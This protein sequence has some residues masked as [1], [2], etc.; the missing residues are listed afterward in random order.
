MMAG[1]LIPWWRFSGVCALALALGGCA[2]LPRWLPG[3]GAGDVTRAPAEAVPAE[4]GSAEHAAAARDGDAAGDDHA[5]DGRLDGLRAPPPAAGQGA[6]ALDLDAAWRLAQLHDPR[7]LAAISARAAS[8]DERAVGRAA[9][10]PQ[11]QASAYRG[12]VR[13]D[14]TMPDFL[15][16]MTTSDLGYDSTS[17]VVQ[18]SQ[19]VLDYGRFAEFRRGAAQ[20]E[21]GVARFAVA[22][23]EAA[24][25][26][27]SAYYRVVLAQGRVDLQDALVDAYTQRVTAL[28]ARYAHDAGTRTEVAETEARLALA[29]ADRVDARDEHALALRA[30]ALL[31]GREPGAL[32]ARAAQLAPAL[33]Q[34]H[35]LLAWLEQAREASPQLRLAER[36][37]TLARV[38]VDAAT[39]GFLPRATL[40]ASLMHA[41]SED[42]ASLSQKSNT[43]NVGLQ[44]Q[45][46][47]FAGGYHS[48]DRARAAARKRQSESL[49]QATLAGVQAEVVRQFGLMEGGVERVAALEQAAASARFSL[50]ATSKSFDYGIASNLEVL[51]A[52]EALHTARHQ[53]LTARV[54]WRMAQLRLA[55]AAGGPLPFE[56]SA[57]ASAAK[58]TPAQ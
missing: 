34:P 28:A 55:L 45:V 39:A 52:Q 53:L 21:E 15:G 16:R 3:G 7:Y 30:L 48:A 44:V 49:V 4:A 14:R 10:L 26:L 1:P 9:I 23:S 33:P 50:E 47:L 51:K 11:V 19:P 54:D 41:D 2:A 20:A 57:A 56:E 24:L 32:A 8:E 18:L 12:R 27:V 38:G 29:E 25:R 43:V 17:A 36:Q 22:H 42:I 31:I 13:G 46:P 5:R 37:H 40:V 6:G 35:S 58:P